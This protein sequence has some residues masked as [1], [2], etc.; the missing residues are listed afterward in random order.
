MW[1]KS[2]TSFIEFLNPLTLRLFVSL[3]LI[4]RVFFL[5]SVLINTILLF[6]I[7]NEREIVCGI[8]VVVDVSVAVR[9]AWILG[10]E[11]PF[12]VNDEFVTL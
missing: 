12:A 1:R 4:P 10:R 9:N 8:D 7:L 3:F 5:R 11:S 6:L 2:R